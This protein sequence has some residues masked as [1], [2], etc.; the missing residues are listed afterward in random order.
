MRS[1]HGAF[2]L[3]LLA[4]SLVACSG[5]REKTTGK[6]S[7][8]SAFIAPGLDSETEF[9]PG[10]TT[11]GTNDII[12]GVKLASVRA[13]C[14]N[15]PTG[16]RVVTLLTFI[17]AR[18][19]DDVRQRDFTYFVAIA[20]ARQNIIAKKD[21]ALRVDFAPRQQEMRIF[22]EITEHLPLKDISQGGGYAVI[23]GLQVTKQ[24]LDLNRKRQ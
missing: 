16:L 7:C 17:A 23:V 12:Y 11:T 9:R 21:F 18:S 14:H 13:S 22:D 1:V 3:V 8:P 24:Q 6:L 15:E 20:D 2:L 19:G 4:L 10:A 5:S